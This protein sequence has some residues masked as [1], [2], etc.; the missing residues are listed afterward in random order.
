MEFKIRRVGLDLFSPDLLPGLFSELKDENSR[1]RFSFCIY[2]PYKS[3][4]SIHHISPKFN[5]TGA[6]VSAYYTTT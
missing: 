2:L 6:T 3:K 4:N 5:S 1:F